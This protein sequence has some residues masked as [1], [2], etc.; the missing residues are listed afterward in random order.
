MA[1]GHTCHHP[2]QEDPQEDCLE[3]SDMRC[4]IRFD[5]CLDTRRQIGGAGSFP[6]RRPLGV[7]TWCNDD[8]EGMAKGG[9]AKALS[10]SYVALWTSMR[11]AATSFFG[12]SEGLTGGC[13]V[14]RRFLFRPAPEEGWF[15]ETEG[16]THPR[17]TTV[18]D[19]EHG[20]EEE[21]PVNSEQRKGEDVADALAS[22]GPPPILG[23]PWAT[24][25]LDWPALLKVSGP[26]I[27][28]GSE[29]SGEP[30]GPKNPGPTRATTREAG[31][32]CGATRAVPRDSL[33]PPTDGCLVGGASLVIVDPRHRRWHSIIGL[34]W[35]S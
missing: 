23:S 10:R 33:G 21:T 17:L 9:G 5:G 19:E 26:Q 31:E 12:V 11:S 6:F 8:P 4:F 29:F 28:I 30:K 34:L 15:I 35:D 24:A 7:G 32:G 22:E 1:Q 13:T 16:S 2:L 25:G 27:S 18:E 3:W 20:R 14:D